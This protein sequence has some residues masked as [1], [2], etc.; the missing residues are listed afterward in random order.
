MCAD[1]L[2]RLVAFAKAGPGKAGSFDTEARE[3]ALALTRK[4]DPA[5]AKPRNVFAQHHAMS[6]DE[7]LADKGMRAEAL[8]RDASR[9]LGD[10]KADAPAAPPP[11]QDPGMEFENLKFRLLGE[12]IA[13]AA[14]ISLDP[15]NPELVV[16]RQLVL[17]SVLELLPPVTWSYEKRLKAR[18]A[19]LAGARYEPWTGSWVTGKWGVI[20]LLQKDG[21]AAA[22]WAGGGKL[23]GEVKGRSLVG[24]W[25][26]GHARG[27]FQFTL[28]DSDR[29]FEAHLTVEMT[30]PETW[31]ATRKEV[32]AAPAAPA[33]SEPAGEAEKSGAAPASP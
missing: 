21:K 19:A 2:D 14:Q 7:D 5:S 33:A 29:G 4:I 31:T 27:G 13:F 11:A 24:S 18:I 15:D 20:D 1:Q 10:A 26:D 32:D 25:S 6:A 16:L 12:Q 8:K 28:G 3:K 30:D 22:S 9:K 17:K 23:S